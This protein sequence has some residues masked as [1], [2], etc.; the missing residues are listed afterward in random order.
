MWGQMKNQ[1]INQ[2]LIKILNTNSPEAVRLVSLITADIVIHPE[3]YRNRAEEGTTG[4]ISEIVQRNSTLIDAFQS[5]F[6]CIRSSSEEYD[7]LAGQISRTLAGTAADELL[8]IPGRLYEAWISERT[9]SNKTGGTESNKNL[10][11]GKK[12]GSYYTPAYIVRYMVGNAFRQIFGAS[13]KVEDLIGF[14]MLDPACGGASFLIEGWKQLVEYGLPETEAVAAVFGTDIDQQ[15]VELSI[16]LLTVAVMARSREILSPLDVKIFLQRQLKVGNAL[17]VLDEG[18]PLADLGQTTLFGGEGRITWLQITDGVQWENEFPMCFAPQIP[19]DKRGFDL[20]IGNPP[21][22]SNK[23][24]P[25]PE[26]KY[27]QEN[28]FTARGQFDLAVPFLEQGINLLRKDG[29]LC[30]I[31]SNKFLA[32]DYGLHLRKKLLD[33]STIDEL[34]DVSTLKAFKNAAAYP[35]IIIL[36]KTPAGPKNRA[37]IYRINSWEELAAAKPVQMEQA[38][39][40]D[41]GQNIITTEIDKKVMPVIAKLKNVKGRIAQEKIG[42]GLA[43]PGFNRWVRKDFREAGQTGLADS[44]QPFI[45]AGQI[46]PYVIWQN[47]WIDTGRFNAVRWN[48]LKGPKLVVP[49]IAR[50]L[51]AALDFTD[52]LLGRVYFIREGDTDFDLRYLVVLMNSLVLNFYYRVMYWPVHLAGGYLRFNSGYLANLPIWP[53]FCS[54]DSEGGKLVRHIVK[55]GD[56]LVCKFP[57]GTGASLEALLCEAEAAVFSLYGFDYQEAGVIMQFLGTQHSKIIKIVR[58]MKEGINLA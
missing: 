24:I 17:S 7:L 37:D 34:T 33:D 41:D 18:K 53:I 20:V 47:A 49:G 29:V 32:A 26:K 6:A 27:Y 51:T 28:Y 55:L 4:H 36:H 22:V 14:K 50:T 8:H 23:L 13:P 31:T 45:Q 44:F 2:K 48:E 12:Q 10:S 25:G 56:R 16:F 3:I 39:F 57:K 9:G 35:V 30:Y 15:A 1:T 40:R 46:K 38:F 21:Y 52:S 5:F 19:S 58:L 43:T 11:L 42:C 54:Q